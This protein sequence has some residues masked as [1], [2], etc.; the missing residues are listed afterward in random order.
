MRHL[1]DDLETWTQKDRAGELGIFQARVTSRFIHVGIPISQTI[2]SEQE[3]LALPAI[4]ADA[5]IDPAS[6]P[7][8]ALLTEALLKHGT[9]RLRRRTL[10]ILEARSISDEEFEALVDAVLQQLAEWDGTVVRLGDQKTPKSV[11]GTARLWCEELDEISG[12]IN[13]KLLCRTRHEFPEDGL[14]LKFIG[15]IEQYVCDEFRDGWSTPLRSEEGE[16]DAADLD[17][18]SG[19]RL[20]E[21]NRNWKFGLNTSPVRLLMSGAS[22]GMTG[23]I[24]AQRLTRETPFLLLA[25]YDCKDIIEQ[26]GQQ[27]GCSG[28]T[29]LTIRSGLP[30][31]WSLYSADCASDDTLVSDVFPA[32]SFPTTVQINLHG[33]ISA[34]PSTYFNFA[35]PDLN[36]VGASAAAELI[37][38][39]KVLGKC[40]SSAFRLSEANLSD[41]KLTFEVRTG[42]QTICK[43]SIYVQRGIPWPQSAAVSWCD[44][45]GRVGTDTLMPRAAGSVVVD[46]E[47]STFSAW[48]D[49]EP[50]VGDVHIV[51][52]D[53]LA[54][55][56][57]ASPVPSPDPV[58]IVITSL[59]EAEV[60]L[61]LL[62][63]KSAT[64]EKGEDGFATL[65][66]RPG[67]PELAEG[68]LQYV[69][70]AGQN[71]SR[72][73]MRCI[74]E[75]SDAAHSSDEIVRAVA[76][77]ILQLVFHKSGRAENASALATQKLPPHFARL[78][79]F[80]VLLAGSDN[81]V[82][83]Q[84]TGIGI[85]DISPLQNDVELERELFGCATD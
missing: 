81:G 32:L 47:T 40:A 62:T 21:I 37:C 76:I 12:R 10:T 33:G 41:A 45:L 66:S 18:C 38:N 48:L 13:I 69:A 57:A 46:S 22:E 55:E 16:F 73:W 49:Q 7:S 85:G 35:L 71:G 34:S 27:Q 44:L 28:L 26:W 15:K 70:G 56:P 67:G 61:L 1:W 20:R 65:K 84:L 2:L 83:P 79:S 58:K 23:F 51:F 63:W 39:G 77:G 68:Y 72:N 11:F 80:M 52:A 14:A 82:R 8:E 36:V 78:Q 64:R 30:K 50:I 19:E 42:K 4:F 59:T 31:G 24:E 25:R 17:W 60:R 5:A 53:Q 54:T 74:K 9:S 75:L 6:T 29:R 43:R 3:R